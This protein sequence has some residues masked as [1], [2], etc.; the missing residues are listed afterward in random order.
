MLLSL[1]CCVSSRTINSTVLISLVSRS[2][3]SLG[4]YSLINF[5]ACP[6]SKEFFHHS[7]ALSADHF[8]RVSAAFLSVFPLDA[9]D[10]I[11]GLNTS[12]LT[13][14]SAFSLPLMLSCSSRQGSQDYLTVLSQFVQC[15]CAVPHQPQCYPDR[16]K[17]FYHS[18]TVSKNG[19]ES[20]Y[21]SQ[22]QS[23]CDTVLYSNY[24]CRKAS[25]FFNRHRL[26]KYSRIFLLL[27]PD[28]SLNRLYTSAASA[29]L[30]REDRLSVASVLVLHFVF[31]Y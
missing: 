9:I 3:V 17:R 5:L 29:W 10:P 2:S 30:G 23:L 11:D 14:P 1:Q 6:C 21:Y 16:A 20:M 12:S 26:L 8:G 15:A 18:L 7:R 28:L 27:Y 25:I 31:F 4:V 24:F 13:S 22:L 19:Y